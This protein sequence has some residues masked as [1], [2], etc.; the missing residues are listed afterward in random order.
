MADDKNERHSDLSSAAAVLQ[1]LMKGQSNALSDSFLRWRLWGS[2]AE[3]VG[4]EIAASS[5]PVGFHK[6][7]LYVWCKSGARMQEMTFMVRPLMTKINTFI[8]KTWVRSIRF[9][10]DK[11]AVPNPEEASS[12]FKSFV[13]SK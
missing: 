1:S 7:T 13:E 4:P 3:L 2:W 11:K 6:G 12:E 8:G 9:T 10:L 5:L